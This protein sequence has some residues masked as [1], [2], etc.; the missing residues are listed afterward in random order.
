[1]VICGIDPSLSSTGVCIYDT[2]SRK[3]SVAQIDG[4][5]KDCHVG[6][7][8][9]RIAAAVID[10]ICKPPMEDCMTL[11]VFIEQPGGMLQGPAQDLR[12]LYWAIIR[13]LEME[14]FIYPTI[15]PVAPAT[16]KKWLTGRGNARPEDKAYA[17]L[18]KLRHLLPEEYVVSDET[19]GGISKFKDAYDAVALAALGECR[20][21]EGEYS[22][23]QVEAV[24]K[25]VRL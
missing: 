20:L 18:T 22:K 11:D 7:R 15:F 23:A 13:H 8:C 3:T 4:H 1:M 5:H 6:A 2:Q 24:K 17:V 9:E 14:K 10:A 12:T 25:V 21:G 19:K 16:L